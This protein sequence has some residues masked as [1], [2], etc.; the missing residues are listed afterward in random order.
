[1]TG[2]RIDLRACSHVDR[3]GRRIPCPPECPIGNWLPAMFR[4]RLR[5]GRLVLRRSARRQV[6]A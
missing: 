2:P 3:D 5:D 4:R 1:M 6:T